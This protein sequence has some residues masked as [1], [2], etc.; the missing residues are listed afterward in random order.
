MRNKDEKNLSTEQVETQTR[1]RF[2][3]SHGH[4]EWQK[5]HSQTSSN[6]K[7][8]PKRL[9]NCKFQKSLRLLKRGDFLSLR[10]ESRRFYGLSV[11][12]DY[13][14]SKF[15]APKLGV[16]VSK[17]FGNACARNYFKRCVR[18]AFRTNQAL[19]P[20]KLI[21]QVCPIHGSKEPS[22]NHIA[23]DFMKFVEK[24]QSSI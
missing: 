7:S 12:I 17:K 18:E 22:L 3:G 2:Q 13:A 20:G 9:E 24:I 4:K 5:D 15:E 14:F 19:F 6:R 10:K 16:T 23:Q 21:M 8:C 11:S 1:T